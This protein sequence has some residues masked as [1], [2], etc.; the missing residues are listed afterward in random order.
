MTESS[1]H[2][3][4]SIADVARDGYRTLWEAAR[5][6]KLKPDDGYGQEVLRA[7]QFTLSGGGP[8]S[9]IVFLLDSDGD[10]KEGF[11]SYFE[12]QGSHVVPIPP[13]DAQMIYERLSDVPDDED[14]EDDNN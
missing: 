11:Y 4:H 7:V 9:D 12:S 1:F 5:Q 8:G 6:G 14:D 13:R 3:H 10:A 2:P